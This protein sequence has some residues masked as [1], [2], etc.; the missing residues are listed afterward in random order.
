[1]ELVDWLLTYEKT[2]TR[3]QAVTIGQGLL[4]SGWLEPVPNTREG[5]AVFKD[6]YILYQPGVTAREVATPK[7]SFWGDTDKSSDKSGSW[8]ESYEKNDH[9]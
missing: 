5:R 4:D 2:S 6:E 7:R 9:V 1:S 3:N 8:N